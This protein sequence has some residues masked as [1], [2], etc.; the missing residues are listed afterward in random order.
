MRVLFIGTHGQDNW[1]DELLLRVFVHQLAPAVDRFAIN[2]Y[3]PA[4]TRQVLADYPVE[5]FH[6]R[7]Q[8]HQLI[9]QLARADA[10][11]F[12]GGS[13]LK[14]LYEAYGGKRYATL[15]AIA[16]VVRLGAVVFRKP[17]YLAN[18]GVGPLETSQ[19]LQMTRA[20]MSWVRGVT[21]R[22]S[23]S[24]QLLELA[25]AKA[26]Y[27]QVPDAVFSIDREY[28]ELPA[29]RTHRTINSLAN[30]Q[31]LG[32]N[33]CRHISN[34][35]NWDYFIAQLIDDLVAALTVNPQLELVGLP[36]QFDTPSNDDAVA[37]AELRRRLRQRVPEV[38]FEIVK[39]RSVAELGAAIDN[40]DIL[41]AE[42]LHAL[43]LAVIIGV[44]VVALEYDIK[45]TATMHDL[46]LAEHGLNIN[47]RFASGSIL[48]RLRAVAQNYRHL[49]DKLSRVQ[50]R[51]WYGARAAFQLL[52]EELRRA[53]RQEEYAA[54][55]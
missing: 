37:L 50:Q 44:P 12:G 32:I 53:R 54:E 1:G 34:S 41:M 10:V 35:R 13:I 5:T 49:A 15:K 42:R 21:V 28:L 14:E 40:L 26:V 29:E 4:Q 25:N 17:V 2:S 3:R 16:L 43:I 51:Q 39:P 48:Q 30:V 22:D 45:V 11:V 19:G 7:K 36:M 31:R 9:W 38:R 23:Q 18:V 6:T 55:V 46:D 24:Y 52:T 33:L 27:R 20:I 47:E 8:P